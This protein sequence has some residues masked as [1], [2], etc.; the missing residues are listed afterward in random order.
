MHGLRKRPRSGQVMQCTK[1]RIVEPSDL[2]FTG[3]VT[4]SGRATTIG[5]K[6]VTYAKMQDITAASK[7]LGR[8]SAG[9][10]G[11]PQEITLGST[12]V[13]TGTTLDVASTTAPQFWGKITND[14][15]IG[16]TTTTTL[17]VNRLHEVQGGSS[18]YTMTL[19]A[20]PSTNDVVGVMVRGGLTG[21]FKLDAGA[22]VNICGR[23]RYLVLLHTNVCLIWWNGS[24][25][26]PLVLNLD[27]PWVKLSTYL[28]SG[29]TLTAVTTS[30]T[31][32]GGTT[33]NN[34]YWRRVANS[35]ALRMEYRQTTAGTA[36]SG[37]YLISVPLGAIDATNFVTAENGAGSSNTRATAG[38]GFGLLDSGGTLIQLA[39]SAYDATKLRL[40]GDASNGAS[41]GFIGS[42]YGGLNIAATRFHF[43]ADLPM[44]D[45]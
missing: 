8:G 33:Y 44:T 26:L 37:D 9:G 27:T 31:L 12:L 1:G 24:A 6:K 2:A 10:A 32:G 30:P 16:V 34:A 14:T 4:V 5:A 17:T 35:M 29:T 18:D 3:D 38:L 40:N 36:G 11:A 20:S 15:V 25:W 43:F 42:A 7:L 22:G 23:T 21:Q 45:W 41:G 28:V 13:M 39:V 19:P